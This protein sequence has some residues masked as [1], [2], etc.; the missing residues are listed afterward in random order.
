MG[1]NFVRHALD[2]FF[3]AYEESLSK[4][5]VFWGFSLGELLQPAFEFSFSNWNWDEADSEPL[6]DLDDRNEH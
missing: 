3:Q 2:E 1:K 4:V 6:E 5:A